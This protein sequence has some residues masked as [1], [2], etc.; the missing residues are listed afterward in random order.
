VTMKRS[1]NNSAPLVSYLIE[2]SHG[3]CEL[4]MKPTESGDMTFYEQ[5]KLVRVSGRE[6]VLLKT[7]VIAEAIMLEEWMADHFC[8]FKDGR[9]AFN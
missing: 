7:E 1:E 5:L 6:T 9:T 2:H 3:T 8:V 4:W